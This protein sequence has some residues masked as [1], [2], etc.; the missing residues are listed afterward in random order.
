[1]AGAVEGLVAV[2]D[3]VHLHAELDAEGDAEVR[4]DVEL[5]V[6]LRRIRAGKEGS[7]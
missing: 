1:M 2:Q 7:N 5:R 4:E 3:D 6:V